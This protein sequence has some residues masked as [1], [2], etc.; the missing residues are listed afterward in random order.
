MKLRKTVKVF[1]G[2]LLVV[3][4]GLASSAS[5]QQQCLIHEDAIQK[6]QNQYSE[7]VTARGLSKYGRKMIELFKSD[8]GSWTIVVTGVEGRSC[9]LASGHSWHEVV[10]KKGINH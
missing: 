7:Q 3:S 8:T 2:T 4:A 5:A 1:L 6:L 10:I 9:V